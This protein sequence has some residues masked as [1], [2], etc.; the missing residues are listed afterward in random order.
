[1]LDAVVLAKNA[2]IL[3]V[4]RG[5]LQVTT[6]QELGADRQQESPILGI[7]WFVAGRSVQWLDP[8]LIVGVTVISKSKFFS[9]AAAIL[10]MGVAISAFYFR[11]QMRCAGFA[12]P[13]VSADELPSSAPV[14]GNLR[15]VAF[16]IRN[17]PLDDRAQSEMLGFSR[18]TNICDLETTLKGLHGDVFAFSEIVDT[19]RFPPILRRTLHPRSFDISFTKS[20]GR[21]GQFVGIA[22]DIEKFE[23]AGEAEDITEVMLTPNLRPALA[24][25][26][27]DRNGGLDLLVISVHFAATPAGYG[28][29]LTQYHNLSV[30]LHQ[31][32]QE[33][34]EADVIV[35]GDFN[36]TGPPGGSIE[37]ELIAT[38]DILGEAGL[39]RL[40]NATGCSEYWEGQEE[41]DG[42][43]VASLL[44]QVYVRSMEELDSSV[45]LESWLHCARFNCNDLVS[46]EGNEDGTF[47]DVSDHCPLTFEV[48]NKDLD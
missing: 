19:R 31:W 24:V 37:D 45:D 47:W 33:H 25:T 12:G 26:L 2:G 21:W 32:T 46:H 38:D 34:G 3:V 43:Q 4:C 7:V 36:T 48:V 18:R 23:M 6:A 42:V 15:F 30:W 41:R 16:N 20:G 14:D 28:S 44:D 40:P 27:K 9:I 1:M 13:E 39:R 10:I 8:R 29:R 35:M 5:F 17:F 11:G 22:W